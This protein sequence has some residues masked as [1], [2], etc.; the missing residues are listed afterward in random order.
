MPNLIKQCIKFRGEKF[1]KYWEEYKEKYIKQIRW[2]YNLDQQT[3]DSL[4]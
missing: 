1:K 4:F 2:S 3:L